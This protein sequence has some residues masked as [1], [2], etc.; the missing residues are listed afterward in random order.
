MAEPSKKRI[1]NT[2]AMLLFA[3]AI[4]FD[5]ISII[6]FVGQ[7]ISTVGGAV[8]FFIWFTILGIPLISPKKI[9]SWGLNLAVEAFPVLGSVWPGITAG[10]ILMVLIT[11][12]EDT[13]GVQILKTKGVPGP[14]QAKATR[15]IQNPGRAL[16]ARARLDRMQ[17][18]RAR[19]ETPAK[20]TPRVGN[21]LTGDIS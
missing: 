14:T 7:F 2:T 10:V 21:D 18:T 13:L 1:S 16:E 17:E 11:R 4:V 3:V 12:T 8:T 9:A 19:A 5:L 20:K 15:R 6:P